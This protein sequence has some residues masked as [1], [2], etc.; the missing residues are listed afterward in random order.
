M[1]ALTFLDI[2]LYIFRSLM[3]VFMYLRGFEPFTPL[4]RLCDFTKFWCGIKQ[5]VAVQLA[6]YSME[7]VL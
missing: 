6:E 7:K 4:E 3:S 5:L 2:I 1:M